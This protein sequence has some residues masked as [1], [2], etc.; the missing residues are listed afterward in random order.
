M[1]PIVSFGI[2]VGTVVIASMVVAGPAFSQKAP[3]LTGKPG[4]AR[5]P[6]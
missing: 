3:T 1:F 5:I 4:F 6:V 2:R